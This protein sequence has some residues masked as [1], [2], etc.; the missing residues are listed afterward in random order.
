VLSHETDQNQAMKL[1]EFVSS[2]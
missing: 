1:I 2:Q